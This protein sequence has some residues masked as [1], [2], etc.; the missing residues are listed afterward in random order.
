MVKALKINSLLFFLLMSFVGVGQEITVFYKEKRKSDYQKLRHSQYRIKAIGG[1]ELS[2][3]MQEKAKEHEKEFSLF[4][5]ISVLRI[6]GQKS[7]HYPQK[8]IWDDT[9][10]SSIAY[11]EKGKT[12]ISR[13]VAQRDHTITFMDLDAKLKVSTEHAYGKDF[14]VEEKLVSQKWIFKNEKKTIGRYSCKKAVLEN[15][16]EAH[17]YI[18]SRDTELYQ[19]LIEVWYTEDIPI[20]SGPIGFWGLP[21][22]ILEIKNGSTHILL[23]KVVFDLDGFIVKPPSVGEKVTRD[24]IDDL[25]MLQFM[26]N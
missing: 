20:K 2:T 23:D 17:E 18:T 5:Y 14:L 15:P 25:P 26:E 7:I 19:K 10:N 9:I 8:K 16:N 12:V 6:K 13:E 24:H 11:G 21:G 3:L 22:L 1:E 4:K